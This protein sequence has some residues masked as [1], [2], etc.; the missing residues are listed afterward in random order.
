MGFSF[1]IHK[2]KGLGFIV[3]SIFPALTGK[4]AHQADQS[5]PRATPAAVLGNQTALEGFSLAF[6]PQGKFFHYLLV[7][8][9]AKMA[10]WILN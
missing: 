3:K 4:D 5:A 9:A 1:I 10:G 7:W 6:D 2:P 8:S